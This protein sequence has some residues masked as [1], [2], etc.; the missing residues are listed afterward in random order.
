MGPS[1]VKAATHARLSCE[2]SWSQ[3][4]IAAPVVR[5]LA[6]MR[7]PLSLG[8]RRTQYNDHITHYCMDYVRIVQHTQLQSREVSR[9][10]L[11]Q[12]LLGREPA[13]SSASW[14]KQEG[15]WLGRGTLATWP[16]WL[17]ALRSGFQRLESP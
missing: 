12:F 6:A 16:P 11:A 3:S 5:G 8:L 14:R 9:F 7:H 1:A 4:E 17:V 13:M 2:Q 10:V 15:L